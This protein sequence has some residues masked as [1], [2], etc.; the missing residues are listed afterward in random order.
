[1]V[2]LLI[3]LLVIIVLLTILVVNTSSVENFRIDTSNGFI[4][5]C[6]EINSKRLFLRGYIQSLRAP[7]QDLSSSMLNAYYGKK[8][9]MN[10][11]N[12]FTDT[13]LA[14]GINTPCKKLAS[15]DVFPFQVLPDMLL[16][17]RTLLLGG[18]DIDELLQKLN[19][20][21]ELLD[22]PVN[23]A[24][25]ATRDTSGNEVFDNSRDVGE[26]DINGLAYELEKLSPYYLSP[27][28]VE[29]LLKFLISREQLNNLNFTSADY[30]E[31]E[32]DL[33]SKI[34]CLYGPD[35]SSC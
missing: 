11:Q 20:Y 9:N 19:F 7:V 24:N 6:N 3:I 1:M 13:C 27:D 22:C 34:E 28:V 33:M 5:A 23:P 16:F 4:S 26:V 25:N 30:V 18:F 10:Y 12:M 17:Y 29:F 15:V 2:I 14:N 35:P 8:E 21:A 32:V 31:Q